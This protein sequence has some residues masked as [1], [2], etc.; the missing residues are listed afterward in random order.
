MIK[1]VKVK[2]LSLSN[3]NVRKRGREVGLE[4]LAASIAANG[5]LQNLVVTPLKK[6][7]TFTV[8]A[9]GRRLRAIRR[10]TAGWKTWGQHRARAGRVLRRRSTRCAR[11][12]LSFSTI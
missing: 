3:D 12:R 7:G 9:G 5:L 2:N 8:K 4:E 10:V 1:S 6:A 11:R